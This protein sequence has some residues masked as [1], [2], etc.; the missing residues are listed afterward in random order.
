MCTY[1]YVCVPLKDKGF[2]EVPLGRCLHFVFLAGASE[3]TQC[4]AQPRKDLLL[5][6]R[7]CARHMQGKAEGNARVKPRGLQT[8]E[9]TLGSPL[10]LR[11]C[12]R[13]T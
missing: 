8:G 10:S 6:N 7:H 12:Q 4:V 13:S 9:L 5:L 11:F 2:L 1:V 3:R